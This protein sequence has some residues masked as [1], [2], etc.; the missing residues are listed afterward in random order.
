MILHVTD[1][2]LVMESVQLDAILLMVDAQIVR[3]VAHHATVHV[4][5]DATVVTDVRVVMAPA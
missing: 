1:V 4:T 3:V 5:V 2:T